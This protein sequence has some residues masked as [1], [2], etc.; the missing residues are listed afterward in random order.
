MLEAGGNV[1]QYE[2]IE[3]KMSFCLLYSLPSGIARIRNNY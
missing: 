3:G 2:H 1:P